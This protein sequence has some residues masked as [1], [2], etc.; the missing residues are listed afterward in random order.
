MKKNIYKG[1]KSERVLILTPNP[2]EMCGMYQLAKDLAKEFNGTIKTKKDVMGWNYRNYDTV[3]TLLYPM[4]MHGCEAKQHGLKWICYD[5][6]IPPINKTTFPN[7]WR[8]CYMQIFNALN[9][10]TKRGADEYWDVTKRPQKP[11]WTRKTKLPFLTY[12]GVQLHLP[13]AVYLG[14]T[15]DYK[16]FKW[17]K[18]KMNEEG[19]PLVHPVNEDDI[20]IHGLLSNAKMLI[21]AS[22]WEG[23]GRPVMESEALGV[24]AVAYNTGSHKKHIKKG[25][26]VPMGDEAAFVKAARKIF[27]S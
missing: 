8:R 10:N 1:K 26:C 13:Y 23:F 24:A 15:T 9:N 20:T 18:K 4:H 11:R 6:G 16:N 27:Y 12:H 17:L 3:I 2:T 25:I 22:L 7:F 19:I 21:T 5:Q 14:R